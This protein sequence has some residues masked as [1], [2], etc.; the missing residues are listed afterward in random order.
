LELSGTY[1][2][3]ADT[4]A[5]ANPQVGGR[6][7]AW[8]VTP[9]GCWRPPIPVVDLPLCAGVGL[10]AMH[11]AGTGPLQPSRSPAAAWISADVSA[12]VVWRVWRDRLGLRVGAAVM[13]A[14]TRP[15]FGFAQAGEVYQ[16]GPVAGRVAAGLEVRLW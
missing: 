15:A 6:F 7:Q 2:T 16:I 9:R 12:A 11:G 5:T 8:Q 10:G 14:L 4:T 1:Y 3:P 13:P